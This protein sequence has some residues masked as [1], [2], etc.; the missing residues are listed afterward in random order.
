[1]E[2]KQSKSELQ[3]K[4]LRIINFKPKNHPVSELYKSNEILKLTDYIKLLS[5]MFVKDTLSANQIPT[6]NNLFKKTMKSTG[7]IPDTLLETQLDSH[8]Q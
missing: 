3:D 1:M 8:N 7:T 4:A 2:Q 6:F 5:C